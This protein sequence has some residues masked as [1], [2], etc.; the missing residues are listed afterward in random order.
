MNSK[1]IQQLIDK[2]G[3]RNRGAMAP[4]IE[5]QVRASDDL[6]HSSLLIALQGARLVEAVDT[7]TEVLRGPQKSILCDC[8]GK[9]LGIGKVK[10]SP[11]GKGVGKVPK[12]GKEIPTVSTP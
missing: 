3:G 9:G 1:E 5:H 11:K 12:V 2:V 6:T 7:L 10:V 8:G 4:S